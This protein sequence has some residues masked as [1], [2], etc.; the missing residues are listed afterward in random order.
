MA[1]QCALYLDDD[2]NYFSEN[3]SIH[4]G[5]V[6]S[7]QFLSSSYFGLLA[8]FLQQF[9]SL[10]TANCSTKIILQGN[11]QAKSIRPG[12]KTFQPALAQA[13]S[14]SSRVT[15]TCTSSYI[16]HSTTGHFRRLNRSHKMTS[17]QYV[18]SL[19]NIYIKRQN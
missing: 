6:T 3:I 9:P 10:L 11:E 18:Y 13:S 12:R 19:E 4:C 8:R 1:T 7:F 15:E 17:T 16:Y 2:M 5:Y 14:K